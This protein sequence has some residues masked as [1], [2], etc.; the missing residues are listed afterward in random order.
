MKTTQITVHK[1]GSVLKKVLT[2]KSVTI[3]NEIVPK[4][5]TAIV[6]EALDGKKKYGQLELSNGRMS[7]IRTGDLMIGMLGERKALVGIVGIVPQSIRVGDTLH[8][9]NIAGVL[10]KAVSWNK[11]VV[12]API[13]VR[14]VGTV[15]VDGKPLLLNQIS[16]KIDEDAVFST[17][18]IAVVGTAMNV[19]KT[20]AAT[21]I[22][23]ALARNT[24][25]KVAAAKLTGVAAQ[26][27]ILSMEDAGAMKTITFQDVGLVS[28]VNNRQLATATK[29]ALHML[30]EFKPDVIV[31]ELGDGLIGWYG[32]DTLLKDVAFRKHIVF[33]LVCAHDLVGAVAATQ[34]LKDMKIKANFFAGPVSNNTAGT[35]YIEDKLKIPAEDIRH[36]QAKLISALKKLPY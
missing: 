16:H 9:L 29:T 24:K 7:K 2:N 34:L 12:T 14:A 27:D 20:T 11:D 21:E 6:V 3:S 35:D 8:V 28:T 10:G 32:V 15:L 33:T 4:S 1:I 18:I 5:G 23:R 17:P 13:R 25:R 30:E 22:I 36:S 19:G 26:R 31:V